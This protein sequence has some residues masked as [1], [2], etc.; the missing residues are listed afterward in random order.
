[1]TGALW[2]IPGN[3]VGILFGMW[4][5]RKPVM[6]LYSFLMA[7]SLL[8]FIIGISMTHS[9]TQEAF[10]HT[11]YYGIKFVACIG[12]IV[13]YQY[14]SEIYPTETRATGA[15]FCIASGRIGAIIAPLLFEGIHSSLGSWNMFFY[16]LMGVCI[17]N[18]LSI[19]F[20]PFET[21]DKVL[22]DHLVKDHE[23][24]ASESYGAVGDVRIPVGAVSKEE[25]DGEVSPLLDD[26][27]TT[28]P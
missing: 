9:R 27:C 14:A 24:D 16:L 7:S 3:A 20:L 6:R 1:M 26:G 10:F 23:S 2:E 18:F 5:P 4:L 28:S 21:A 15:S 19:G 12:Y 25:H 17:I 11:G 8:I 22:Q 13:V